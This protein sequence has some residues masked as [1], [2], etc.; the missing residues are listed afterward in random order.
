MVFSSKWHVF[1]ASLRLRT[2]TTYRDDRKSQLS[3]TLDLPC[4]ISWWWEE[5]YEITI[6]GDEIRSTAFHTWP[7]QAEFNLILATDNIRRVAQRELSD[8]EDIQNIAMPNV[9]IFTEHA[10]S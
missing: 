4:M 9:T 10:R 6:G 3:D 7:P 2:T 8:I 5:A 1:V